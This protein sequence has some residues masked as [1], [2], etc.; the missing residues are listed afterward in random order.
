MQREDALRERLLEAAVLMI[1]EGSAER[2]T[3]ESVAASAE[4]ELAEVERLFPT[5]S[6]LINAVVERGYDVLKVLITE[7]MGN[8]DAPGAYLRGYIAA[9][10]PEAAEKPR[11]TVLLTSLLR[12]APLDYDGLA[13]V[14]RRHQQEDAAIVAD[15][16]D[17][18]HARIIRLAIDGLYLNDVFGLSALTDSEREAVLD[19]LRQMS[20]G[21]GPS[22]E[23]AR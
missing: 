22:T 10:F 18:V 2:V 6:A 9:A 4:V 21:N 3:L 16:L 17:P 19:R 11:I 5:L 7:E 15:G 20:H 14:R 13:P 8:D 1:Q 23:R 12:S